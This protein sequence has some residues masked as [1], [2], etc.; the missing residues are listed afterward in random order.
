MK[1][2]KLGCQ[3]GEVWDKMEVCFYVL[4]GSGLVG[5]QLLESALQNQQLS[6]SQSVL[7]LLSLSFV[8]PAFAPLLILGCGR[9]NYRSV[10]S[11]SAELGEFLGSLQRCQIVAVQCC[12]IYS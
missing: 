5:G 9:G 7:L 8:F 1:I 3:S 11:V 6:S 4:S 10:L 12:R 2:R